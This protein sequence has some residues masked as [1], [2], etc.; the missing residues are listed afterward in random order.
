MNDL[1]ELV[2]N[3]LTVS[4]I[5][6]GFHVVNYWWPQTSAAYLKFKRGEDLTSTEKLIVGIFISFVAVILDN[7]YWGLAWTF[8]YLEHPYASI[9]ISHGFYPNIP[10][11]QGLGVLAAYLH[12]VAY[13][14]TNDGTGV[15]KAVL[16]LK[17]SMIAG[18]VYSIAL[19]SYRFIAS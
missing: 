18:L 8:H 3:G 15:D 16:H 4:L 17:I 10:F 5:I 9:M 11:R 14:Q 12:I 1:A 6:L 2:S 13:H 19:F 7:L